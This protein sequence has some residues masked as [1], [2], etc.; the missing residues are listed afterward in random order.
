MSYLMD[1][2]P[3]PFVN[4]RV[5]YEP[6]GPR[7]K[8]IVPLLR[9]HIEGALKDYAAPASPLVRALDVGCG[10]QPFRRTLESFGYSFTG[11]DVQQNPENTVDFIGAIDEALPEGLVSRGPFHFILCTEVLEH[12]ADWDK[13][14]KNL[15]VLLERGGCLLITCP[16][17]YRLHEEPYDFWRPTLHALRYF[18]GRAG[19]RTLHD[20]AAGGA[21]DVLGTLLADCLPYSSSDHV[22]AR[23]LTKLVSMSIRVV[24]KLLYHGGLQ[25]TVRLR[26]AHYLSNVIVFEL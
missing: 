1:N 4:E 12:V 21:W 20:V 10:R 9:R 7:E 8:F 24:L 13:A 16:Q 3:R 5:D 18:G 19:F 11:M 25:R 22:A 23:G 14:F 17:F 15:A 6:A 2:I 26:S